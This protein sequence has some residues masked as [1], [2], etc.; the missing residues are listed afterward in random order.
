[1]HFIIKRCSFFEQSSKQMVGEILLQGV[2]RYNTKGDTDLPLKTQEPA[3][4][5][6]Q[7][8]SFAQLTNLL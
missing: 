6:A 7:V 2:K 1:M 4:V 5:Q 8:R 3:L